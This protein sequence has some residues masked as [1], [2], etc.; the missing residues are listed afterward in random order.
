VVLVGEVEVDPWGV[1][2]GSTNSTGSGES[3]IPEVVWRI[4]AA[5][6]PP[7]VYAQCDRGPQPSVG[8][9]PRSGREI[10]RAETWSHAIGRPLGSIQQAALVLHMIMT[11]KMVAL[12]S[13]H[14]RIIMGQHDCICMPCSMCTTRPW[15]FLAIPFPTH[16]AAASSIFILHH[17]M[18]TGRTKWG[19]LSMD[20]QIIM[21]AIMFYL[22]IN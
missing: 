2:S 7:F 13:H 6:A 1:G 17:L 15:G 5:A 16:R 14:H 19:R 12:S 20:M 11:N 21:N 22:A 8:W 18:A 4:P 10:K 9:R 3:R